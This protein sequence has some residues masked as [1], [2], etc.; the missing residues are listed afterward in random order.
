MNL[1]KKIC[2]AI[3]I[4]I[5]TYILI[6]LFQKRNILVQQYNINS[7]SVIEGYQNST[8][9]SI[10]QANTCPINIQDNLVVRL[11]NI[12]TLTSVS[13]VKGLYLSNYAIKASMNTAYDGVECTTDMINYVLTRGCRFLD[14]EVYR[15][16]VSTSTIVSVSTDNDYTTP[17]SQSTILTISDAM[18]Y[19]SM[20]GLNST[21][22]NSNDPLF[23]QFR[24]RIPKTDKEDMYAKT[25]YND[26]YNACNTYLLQFLYPGHIDDRTKL[27]DLLGQIVL[28][29]DT[30]LY[31]RYDIFCPSLVT[32]I[33]IDN[34]RAE[35]TKTFYYGNLPDQEPL[36]LSTDKYSCEVSTI[37]QSLWINKNNIDYTSNAN[38]YTLYKNYSCQIV[39]MLFYNNGTDLYNY[40][41]LFN[42]CGGGI[43]PL[44][45]IYGKVN[46][47]I[48][49]YISYPEPPFALPNYG[50]QTVSIIIITACLGIAGFIIYRE[51]Q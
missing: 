33:N 13:L 11:A 37:N 6:R 30:T 19:V 39:P 1:T 5:F 45:L 51:A 10:Q 8:V 49:P 47:D 14:F 2:I 48:S 32:V 23:I 4:I 17:I 31:P 40:E 18:N 28:V 41:M 50:N 46:L 25:I 42:N 12:T 9:N 26:I 27:T 15:D 16:P 38:S 22:P 36:T 29:M 44:S 24:P 43:V 21:C 3:I 34:N 20:Y 7:N 35:E